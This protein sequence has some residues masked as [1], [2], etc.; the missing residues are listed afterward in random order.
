MEA[1][2]KK[3][4][5]SINENKLFVKYYY[6]RIHMQDKPWHACRLLACPVHSSV[7]VSASQPASQAASVCVPLCDCALLSLNYMCVSRASVCVCV[8]F[9]VVYVKLTLNPH[10]PIKLSHLRPNGHYSN[11]RSKNHST[12]ASA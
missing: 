12:T 1:K 3:L 7:C 5:N 4:E 9:T 6:L 11:Q 2:G 8:S 10:H